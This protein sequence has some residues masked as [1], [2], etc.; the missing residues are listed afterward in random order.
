VAGDFAAGGVP[1]GEELRSEGGGPRHAAVVA[2]E[3]DEEKDQEA[4]GGPD[5]RDVQEVVD[6]AVP[7]TE[8]VAIVTG[9]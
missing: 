3:L 2:A 4:A 5:R 8:G 1:Y 7:D 9:G 6:V